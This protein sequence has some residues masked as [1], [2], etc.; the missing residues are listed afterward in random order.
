MCHARQPNYSFISTIASLPGSFVLNYRE[1]LPD[2]A[3]FELVNCHVA[4]PDPIEMW[5]PRREGQNQQTKYYG[6][7]SFTQIRWCL[8]IGSIGYGIHPAEYNLGKGLVRPLA[9]ALLSLAPVYQHT[10]VFH[11]SHR[12]CL[13]AYEPTKSGGLPEKVDLRTHMSPVED[14]SLIFTI[15]C[16]KGGFWILPAGDR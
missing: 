12:P 8:G 3:C 2:W 13:Q 14:Q 7:Q 11:I 15:V 16:L 5:I 10:N 4:K 9:V 6:S 1:L